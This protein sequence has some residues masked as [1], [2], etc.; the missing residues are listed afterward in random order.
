MIR[1]PDRFLFNWLGY[2]TK[3]FASVSK[4]NFILYNQ[5]Y[6]FLSAFKTF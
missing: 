4:M 1:A 2:T 6:T 3:T 5:Y